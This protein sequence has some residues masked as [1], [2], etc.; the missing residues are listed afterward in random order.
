[1]VFRRSTSL[2]SFERWSS[3]KLFLTR[4][5]QDQTPFHIFW[6]LNCYIFLNIRYRRLFSK[7]P[8]NW[9]KGQIWVSRRNIKQG[10]LT[11]CGPYSSHF[12][13]KHHKIWHTCLYLCYN[14]AQK[15][16][17]VYSKTILQ[18]YKSSASKKVSRI[19]KKL[20]FFQICLKIRL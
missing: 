3:A 10:Q 15:I 13:L 16:S 17:Y 2:L 6:H 4:Q 8:N 1:M 9:K 18:K 11:F 7:W 20:D 12:C 14:T 5:S 19:V